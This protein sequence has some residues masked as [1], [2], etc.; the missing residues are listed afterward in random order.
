MKKIFPTKIKIYSSSNDKNLGFTIT[1]MKNR[2]LEIKTLIIK[3]I[4]KIT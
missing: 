3:V 2:K 1:T 4:E